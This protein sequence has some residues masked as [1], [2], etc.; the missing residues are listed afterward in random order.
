MASNLE[1]HRTSQDA[2]YMQ[3]SLSF[4]ETGIPERHSRCAK[5]I[6]ATIWMCGCLLCI[7][8]GRDDH[9]MLCRISLK[10]EHI[11][12]YIWRSCTTNV[13][14]SL[15]PRRFIF[16]NFLSFVFLSRVAFPSSMT[17]NGN[18]VLHHSPPANFVMF[19]LFTQLR[20][21]ASTAVCVCVCLR[22]RKWECVTSRSERPTSDDDRECNADIA[23]GC[24]KFRDRDVGGLHVGPCNK[25][26]LYKTAAA[27]V[28]GLC[29]TVWNAR[30][31][32]NQQWRFEERIEIKKLV[33]RNNPSSRFI[34]IMVAWHRHIL[35]GWE[36]GSR[37]FGHVYIEMTLMQ[38]LSGL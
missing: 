8:F 32:L 22:S 18:I 27:T 23:C 4:Y 19:L 24:K 31:L 1:H 36:S 38:R 29:P 28:D 37:H 7:S 14:S 12:T 17:R 35:Y 16:Y 5:H 2:N 20:D 13:L 9:Y 11:Y 33:H 30:S 10:K 34:T 26:H 25:R 6:S 21:N 15:R 3:S